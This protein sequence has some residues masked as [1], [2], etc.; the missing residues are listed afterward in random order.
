MMQ[1]DVLLPPARAALRASEP[2]ASGEAHF[3]PGSVLPPAPYGHPD[4]LLAR[5]VRLGVLSVEDADL[6]GTTCL[7]D[8]PVAVYADRIGVSRWTVYKRRRAAEARLFEA[9]GSGVLSDPDAEVIAEATLTTASEPVA[10]R[11]P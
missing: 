8:V 7:E 4:L 1:H 3:A 5:A 10:R 9:L 6:I 11:R 2:A